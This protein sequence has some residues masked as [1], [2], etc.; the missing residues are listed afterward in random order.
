M[1]VPAHAPEVRLDGVVGDLTLEIIVNIGP[2]G[3][4]LYALRGVSRRWDVAQDILVKI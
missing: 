4:P 1:D 2:V 3:F